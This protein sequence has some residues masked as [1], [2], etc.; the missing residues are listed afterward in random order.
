MSVSREINFSHFKIIY[1]IFHSNN[2]TWSPHSCGTMTILSKYYIKQ[3]S[4]MLTYYYLHLSLLV[5]E[6]RVRNPQIHQVLVSHQVTWIYFKAF[7]L[8]VCHIFCDPI[9]S[10]RFC[11]PVGRVNTFIWEYLISN[12]HHSNANLYVDFNLLC[13]F[14][15]LKLDFL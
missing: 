10:L 3:N 1:S 6:V 14:Q 5:S 7:C 2:V 8:Y 11:F 15:S 9:F 12:I 13:I 4:L